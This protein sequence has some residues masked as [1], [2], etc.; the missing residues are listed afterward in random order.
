MYV[1]SIYSV[2]SLKAISLADNV[3]REIFIVFF[4]SRSCFDVGRKWRNLSENNACNT[5]FE[6]IVFMLM[7]LNTCHGNS[8]A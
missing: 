1:S 4:L 8:I 3:S 2:L 7:Y 5:V 6:T